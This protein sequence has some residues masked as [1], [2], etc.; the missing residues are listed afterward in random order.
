MHLHL[1]GLLTELRQTIT[2][3]FS[4]LVATIHHEGVRMSED[5]TRLTDAV[6]AF[7]SRFDTFSGT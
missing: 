1:D 7:A 3:G 2:M 6:N 4:Q 5:A